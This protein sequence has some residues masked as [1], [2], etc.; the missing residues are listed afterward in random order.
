LFVEEIKVRVRIKITN[1][2]IFI[3]DDGQL[4]IR[5]FIETFI[6]DSICNIRFE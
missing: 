6:G 4:G 3:N 1:K 5:S 2:I